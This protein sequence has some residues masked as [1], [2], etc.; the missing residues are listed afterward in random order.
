MVYRTGLENRSPCKRTVGSNPTPS[1]PQPRCWIASG[2]ASQNVLICVASSWS[3][4]RETAHS[5]TGSS[6]S[7]RCERGVLGATRIDGAGVDL[8]HVVAE[9]DG[10]RAAGDD[11][12]LFDLVVEV[13]GA[14]LEVG[15]RRDADERDRELLGLEGGVRRRNSPGTSVSA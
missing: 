15:V 4:F 8:G 9:T 12:D 14:L 10:Q 1:A 11:V 6:P 13:A 5:S 3:S 7:L 2:D